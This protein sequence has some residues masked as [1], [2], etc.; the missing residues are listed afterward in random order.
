MPNEKPLG[1]NGLLYFWQSIKQKFATK[2]EVP[3]KT[4]QLTNDSKFITSADIPEGAAASNTPPKM[5]GVATPGTEKTFARGDHIHPTDTS[6]LS[7]TGD[8]SNT[9]ATFNPAEARTAITSGEKLTTI[10]GKIAKYMADFGGLAFKT[11]V[12]KTDLAGDVQTSLNKADSALQSYTETDPTVP[13]WAKAPTKPTYTAQEIGALTTSDADKIYAKKEDITNVYKYKGSKP[14][15]AELPKSGNTIGDVW[16][17]EEN[18]MNYGWTGSV[19]DPLGN[20]F[21]LDFITN[22]EIDQI[23]GS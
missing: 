7:T 11:T 9:S 20:L 2:A 19:W 5:D 17:V 13:E 12:A 3:T 22:G 23:L 8:A 18:D 16:N 21:T 4:S 1:E 15:F 6:R 14:T 10:F